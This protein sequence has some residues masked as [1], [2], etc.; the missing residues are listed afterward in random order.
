MDTLYGEIPNTL[1]ADNINNLIGQV[2]KLLPY[3]EENYYAIDSH[4]S[5]VLLRLSGLSNLTS[6]FPELVTVISILEAA[7]TE[8][9]FYLYRKAIL[10]SC[11]ILKRL[12][13]NCNA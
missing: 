7:R 10:D 12:Q 8:E 2:Y 11:S 4:F 13:E 5:N 6:D 9:N 3:R 1:V